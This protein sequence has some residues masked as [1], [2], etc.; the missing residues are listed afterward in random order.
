MEKQEVRA[1]G[2]SSLTVV[3]SQT[4]HTLSLGLRFF[5]SKMKV[6][7]SKIVKLKYNTKRGTKL[8]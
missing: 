7:S 1:W 2:W 3:L 5:I 4:T 8:E 6:A